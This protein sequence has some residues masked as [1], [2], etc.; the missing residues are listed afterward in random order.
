MTFKIS[1]FERY[2]L[3]D[4]NTQQA[5]RRLHE[6][7]VSQKAI[8]EHYGIS[9]NTVRSYIFN[10]TKSTYGN[11]RRKSRI[12]KQILDS[13]DKNLLCESFK[14]TGNNCALLCKHINDNPEQYGLPKGLT[15][16]DRTVR[17]YMA[18][19][20]P[21]YKRQPKVINT[22]T[23]EVGQQL[24][25]DFTFA[26]Y[27]FAGDKKP[28][29]ICI[30]EAVYPWSHKSFFRICPDTTQ[31]SW[32][33]G[34]SD[35]L[36]QCGIPKEILCD[37]DRALVISNKGSKHVRFHPDF[38]WFCKCYG[39][40]PRACKPSRP[41]TKGA[42]ERA[43][44]YVKE[45]GLRWTKLNFPDIK[46]VDELNTAIQEWVKTYADVERK[47]N[48]ELNGV[49]GR[50]TVAELFAYEKNFLTV[51]KNRQLTISYEMLSADPFGVIH[52]HGIAI[53]LP[54]SY[55]GKDVCISITSEGYYRVSNPYGDSV[56]NGIIPEENLIKYK[57][58]DKP[59]KNTESV[60]SNND[61]KTKTHDF[62]EYHLSFKES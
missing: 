35:C 8:A 14:T 56:S 27:I 25:I 23:C 48:A 54:D 58:K 22:F 60:L 15:I 43:G 41:Q 37:N 26:K 7:G 46:S 36:M 18:K 33:R 29:T 24:Q 1:Y 28:Q 34:I 40:N 42:V 61:E 39:I 55:R 52:V 51:V 47:F 59:V 9:R 4:F 50:Y 13:A 19:L 30:F 17:R 45:N 44:R 12:R 49:E 57:L 31:A 20:M 53:K 10:K 38:E 21:E 2:E 11:G 5:I 62:S 6:E 32:L 3:L 16:S